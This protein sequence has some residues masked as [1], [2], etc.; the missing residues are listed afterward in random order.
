[1]EERKNACEEFQKE[2]ETFLD[3][4]WT[5]ADAVWISKELRK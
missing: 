5:D 2:M 4:K 1:M 3:G